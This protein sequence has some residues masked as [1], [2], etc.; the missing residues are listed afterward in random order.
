MNAKTDV[1]TGAL[2][3]M[4]GEVKK[5]ARAEVAGNPSAGYVANNDKMQYQAPPPGQTY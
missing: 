2:A 1:Q 3:Q 5:K 4:H